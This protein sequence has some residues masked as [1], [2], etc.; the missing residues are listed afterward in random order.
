MKDPSF[1]LCERLAF[2]F[3]LISFRCSESKRRNKE[4]ENL[5]HPIPDPGAGEG[6]PLQSIPDPT[7]ENRDRPRTLPDGT[8]DKDLV[9][10]PADEVEEGAQDGLHEC[11][12]HAP[13]ASGLGVPAP[14]PHDGH[15]PV[16]RASSHGLGTHAP[17]REGTVRPIQL[18]SIDKPES[19]KPD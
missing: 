10:E 2:N 11:H 14:G 4:T 19:G 3:F 6:V 7:T 1:N 5:L 8:A 15:A 17:R 13:D 12:A 18:A 9:P 16:C